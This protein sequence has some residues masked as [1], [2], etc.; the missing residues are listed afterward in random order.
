MYNIVDEF[1]VQTSTLF[2][3][4]LVHTTAHSVHGGY[5]PLISLVHPCTSLNGFSSKLTQSPQNLRVKRNLLPQL[6]WI[7]LC[8]YEVPQL[9]D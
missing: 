8:H 7:Q 5:F 2:S 9:T 3:C 4:S 1:I 6:E